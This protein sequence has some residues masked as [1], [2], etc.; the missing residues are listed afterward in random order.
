MQNTATIVPSH[1]WVA[2]FARNLE[3]PRDIDWEQPGRLTA[4]ERDTIASSIQKFQL[5]E[6]S[7]G[8]NLFRFAQM[9]A[10]QTG[11]VA[12]VDA[13]TLFI[14]EEQRHARELG[15]LMDLE[16]IPRI[17]RTYSDAVFRRVRRLAGLEV[18]IVVLIMAEIIAKV[19]YRALQLA[20]GSPTLHRICQWVL[21]DEVQHVIFQ[22]QRLAILRRE[23]SAV[24][25]MGRTAVHAVLFAPTCLIVWFDHRRVL[26]AGGYTFAGYWRAVW[27]EFGL[28]RSLMNPR[29]YLSSADTEI[30]S[31][32]ELPATYV[33]QRTSP[34]G[35]I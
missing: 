28:A 8:R 27:R 20:T 34:S 4:A 5:G 33:D 17:K 11:D 9:Y 16:N 13:I 29:R 35:A 32:G 3:G 22:S 30:R 18:S 31:P 1:E 2:T 21:I 14:K 7:E 10:G 6:N 24:D 25:V 12:Y 23:C 19:Y 15:R 26:S